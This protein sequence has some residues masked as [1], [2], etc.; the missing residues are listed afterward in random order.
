M[1]ASALRAGITERDAADVI[2]ALMSPEVYRLF[3][4]DRRWSP[5]RYQIWLAD[6]LAQQLLDPAPSNTEPNNVRYAADRAF[7]A[8]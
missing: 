5:D 8:S 4:T 7:G 3:S 2:H 6:T 1:N